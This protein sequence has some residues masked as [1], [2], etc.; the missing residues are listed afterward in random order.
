MEKTNSKDINLIYQAVVSIYVQLSRIRHIESDDIETID[1]LLTSL[2]GNDLRF[3]IHHSS[4]RNILSIRQ[5]TNILKMCLH[6]TDKFKLLLTLFSI[7]YMKKNL[8]LS[9]VLN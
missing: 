3:S 2:L 9:E 8:K 1:S 6:E 7:V 5:A 4:T